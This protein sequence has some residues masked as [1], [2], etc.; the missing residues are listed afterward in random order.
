MKIY[1]L[2]L[3]LML[4]I[5][6]SISSSQTAHDSWDLGFGLSFPRYHDVNINSLNSDYGTYLSLQRNFSENVGLRFKAG[7]SHLEGQWNDAFLNPVLEKTNLLTG[8]LDLVYYLAPCARVS[9]F[10]FVGGGG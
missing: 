7:Y 2:I 3:A 8:D 10:F 1:F 6:T 5:G 4:T 9:P